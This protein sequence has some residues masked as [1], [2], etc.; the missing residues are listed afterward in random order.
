MIYLGWKGSFRENEKGKEVTSYLV[1]ERLRV[2]ILV[3]WKYIKEGIGEVLIDHFRAVKK[4]EVEGN[5]LKGV[6]KR[7]DY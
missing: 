7:D 2:R 6:K 3:P 1:K 5:E 4:E